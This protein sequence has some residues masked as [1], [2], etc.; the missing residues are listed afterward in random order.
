VIIGGAF[1][2]IVSS[3]VSDIIMPLL[4]LLLGNNNNFKNLFITLG[5]G[6]FTTIEAAKD[7]GVATLNY[8]LFLNNILDFLIIAF[9]I[10]IV[11]KQINRFTK[12][13]EA[14]APAPATTKICN[15]CFSE[16]HKDASRC[17][18]CTSELNK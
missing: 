17:P 1:G 7:A 18:H 9:S 3:L 14:P 13:K 10:F 2:K 12:K 15:F 11:V 6:S 8:G 5:K 4:G 16:V